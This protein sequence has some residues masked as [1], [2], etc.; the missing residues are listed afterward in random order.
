MYV[1]AHARMKDDDLPDCIEVKPR[2]EEPFHNLLIDLL[3]KNLSDLRD[4][5]NFVITLFTDISFLYHRAFHGW[6]GTY[7][8]YQFLEV[9]RTFFADTVNKVKVTLFTSEQEDTFHRRREH[10]TDTGQLV[11]TCELVIHNAEK[12]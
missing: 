8:S 4:G 3:V 5:N 6:I 7:T 12:G 10:F 9:H 2:T 1:Q 11:D